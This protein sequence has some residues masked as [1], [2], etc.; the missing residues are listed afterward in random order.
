MTDLISLLAGL[1]AGE[2]V[3]GRGFERLC[4]WMLE[5][6]PEY[7]AR[8]EKVWL[9]E[10]WPAR[11]GR[12]DAGIDLVA[13]E[14][15][16][17]L[18]AV[19]AK[20]Y[21]PAYAIKKADLDSFL[22]ESSRAEFSYRLLIATTDHLGPTARRT[23]D[24]QEKP[25]GTLLRSDLDALDLPWP[26]SL[27][28]L[29]PAK[30]K[31]KRPRP[32]QRQ[33]VNDIVQ[34]LATNERGQVVMACG[35]GKTLVARFL[36]DQLVSHKT[37]VMVPSLSLLKQT[38]R[39]WLAVE[40]FDYLA[41]CSDDTVAAEEHDAVVAS[42][43]ELGVP[44]TT[45][46]GE[47]ASFLR[48]STSGVV[49]A[50]Y[51]SSP[52]IAEAQEGH[53]PAFD[54]VICDEAHRCTG[55][56]AGPF[57][58]ILDPAK[59]KAHRRVFM[60]AT[61]R[62]FTGRVQKEA[63]EADW[64]VASMDDEH[65]FGPVLHRLSF[66][67]AIERDLLSD[68]RV[69][70]VGV[71]D[72]TYRE[73]AER[74]VFVTHDG[75]TVTDARMLASQIGVLRAMA[76]YDLKRLV[77][78]H[79]RIRGAR[80]FVRS[81]LDVAD[82]M[83]AEGRPSGALWAE[84]V[85]GEMTSGEREVKLSRLRA[86]EGGQRGILANARCLSEGVD[87]PTLDGVVFV[88]PRRSQ[89]DVVQAVGR[90]IRKADDKT[91]GTIVIPVFVDEHT[92]P[93]HALDS[94]EF[95]TVWQIVKALRAHDEALAEELDEL[96][97]ERG[98]RR[99]S[100]GRPAKIVLE[101]PV[102]V[103][104]AFA[105]AFDARVVERSTSTWEH[106]LG[107]AIAYREE[108]GNLRVPQSFVTTDGFRLGSWIGSRRG[109]RKANTLSPARVAALDAL[110]MI[111]EPHEANWGRAVAD[112]RAYREQ[113]GNLHV[114]YGFVTDDGFRLGEWLGAR[115][116][117]R[118]RGWLSPKRI[119]E[120]DALGMVWDSREANWERAIAAARA[121][122]EEHGHLRVPSNFV[123]EDGFQLGSW[124]TVRRTP[125]RRL[126][127]ERIAALD[128]LGMV[129]DTATD[130]WRRGLESAKT[131][132]D[133][134]G[135]LR[136][137]ASY[138]MDDGFPLGTW[139]S[140]RRGERKR[141]KLPADHIAALDTL[142]MIWDARE[143]R[144][145][146]GIKAAQRYRKEHGDLLAPVS[147]IAD[148]G[149]RLGTWLFSARQ[150][151]KA[152]SLSTQRIAALD[153]LD[154]S[155]NP[156]TDSWRQGLLAAESY[157]AE[158]G[159]LRVPNSFVGADGYRLGIW[160]SERRADRRRGKLSDER[161]AAL[162]ALGMA[163]NGRSDPW[164]RGL[165]AASAYRAANGDLRV[166]QSFVDEQGFRLG[167]WVAER[168]TERR[169]AKLSSERIAALDALGMVWDPRG[170]GWEQGLS[171][172]RAYRKARGDLDVPR[173][174]VTE[175]GMQLGSWIRA[176][177]NERSS[178]KL[179]EE[180]I[181]ALDALGMVW[182]AHDESWRRGLA[183]AR[184][185]RESHGDLRAR[186][187]FVDAAG[188]AIGAWLD[189]QRQLRKSDKLAVERIA[190]LD[191]IDMVWDVR[192]EGWQAG[193]AAAQ[194]YR[195]EHGNLLAPAKF[196]TE[197]GFKLGAWLSVRRSERIEG[198]LSPDRIDALDS[199]GM[200]WDPREEEWQ[201]GLEA[202][203][204]YRQEHGDLRVPQSFVAGDGFNLGRWI[205][206]RRTGRKRGSLPPDRVAAL[207]ALDMRW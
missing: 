41:V 99:A 119:R 81:V 69:L 149:F 196:V 58:T 44:V 12:R 125:Q 129:W 95:S 132:R 36:H 193:L 37:L 152:G 47:I 150:R 115:R 86:V 190:A 63:K 24:G 177:R 14:R 148:D 151:R 71:S 157:R 96:R 164:E 59:I 114:P 189:R 139:I 94:S 134:H 56:L 65:R 116:A 143:D 90:A 166:P 144:W 136:V 142:G 183:A 33:A 77:T 199:L 106:G 123:T 176:R 201:R 188:F 138:V 70:V 200:V 174:F 87:V 203:R 55:P 135:H 74:G 207:D 159:H 104:E 185:Y 173:S 2:R 126:S 101:L 187:T 32:H 75:E 172:S 98:R 43:S 8:L 140:N 9:W 15:D 120:L 181:A 198:R 89:V 28:T 27:T 72:E 113:H 117:D 62:Y 206:N 26:R 165:L 49:F 6:S 85:S 131:Y 154:M 147:F 48:R 205:A 195:D 84:H 180:R 51:Q 146:R 3:R 46:P 64:E 112:A 97:R 111:W 118:N 78:F 105:N 68:Y 22:A 153:A 82:W 52:R 39:E 161:I 18:W 194:R 66:G 141:N 16:G 53:V 1:D 60:T 91:V 40:P 158:H 168:R 130:D 107:A 38:L 73:Y 100:V 204:A 156:L 20:H 13:Q 162:D 61:P 184:A 197:S 178:G 83:P 170:G 34:G 31:P 80:S 17:G 110:G 79:S 10:E 67:E 7:A 102:S 124:I 109:Q 191:E 30:P 4:R 167:A 169:R 127:P 76:G 19:Q 108:Y 57:T 88:D 35:T 122:H 42:T 155:W 133:T 182:E 137:P 29:R 192:G 92:D 21:D 5:T 160:I 103:G 23:L 145:Q 128:A 175:D 179:P 50:T 202:A 11:Q 93:E 25:V 121:Y 186:A 54:L 45:N 171:A 163:W